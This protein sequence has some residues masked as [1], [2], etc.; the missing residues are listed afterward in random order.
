MAQTTKILICGS[1]DDYSEGFYKTLEISGFKIIRCIP[2]GNAAASAIEQYKPDVVLCDALMTGCDAA[3]LIENVNSVQEHKPFFIV[4]SLYKNAFLEQQIMSF[5]NAYFILKPFDA[6][7]FIKI[8]KRISAISISTLEMTDDNTRLE[9]I[10][11][12]II[13]QIGIPAHIKGYHYLREAIILSLNNDEMLERITKLLYPT[14]AKNFNTTASRVERAIRHAIETA[15]DRGDVDTLTKM[16][17]YTI[18]VGK[19]KPTNSEFIAL[20][21]DNLRLRFRITNAKKEAVHY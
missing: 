1:Q 18:S 7:S 11:T 15:W 6:D 20:I 4:A 12:D 16:F 21:T 5:T 3:V 17:G 19:G 14:V 13:H 10:V 2:D 8:V 9:M